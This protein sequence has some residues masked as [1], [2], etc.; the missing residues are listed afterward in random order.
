MGWSSKYQLQSK[1]LF[2][3]QIKLSQRTGAPGYHLVN[4][5]WGFPKIGLPLVIIPFIHG[6]FH[7]KWTSCWGTPINHHWPPFVIIG[8]HD[9]PLFI[10][11]QPFVKR[12][13]AWWFRFQIP[14]GPATTCCY[15]QGTTGLNHP[16]L[17]S[18]KKPDCGA[19]TPFHTILGDQ[20][21][22]VNGWSI[23]YPHGN[24]HCS[25]LLSTSYPP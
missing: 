8:D 24:L 10:M 11:V 3:R 6:I 13:H 4:L 20:R 25:P 5:T 9:H 14:M 19:T 1:E 23:S 7:S 16:N 2:K 22:S 21:L 18:H 15:H 17:T 12:C